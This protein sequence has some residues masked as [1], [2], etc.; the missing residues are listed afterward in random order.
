[1]DFPKQLQINVF[2]NLVVHQGG[3]IPNLLQR[4][5]LQF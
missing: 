5:I 2:L 3:D 1:M 4:H